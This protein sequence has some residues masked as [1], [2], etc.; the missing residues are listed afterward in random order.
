MSPI[1]LEFQ[2]F[3]NAILEN[4]RDTS[5]LLQQ[6]LNRSSVSV[7]IEIR[8]AEGRLFEN[9]E[10]VIENP[11]VGR[12][13]SHYSF[14]NVGA[15]LKAGIDI[16]NSRVA[17]GETKIQA[18]EFDGSMLSWS[19]HVYETVTAVIGRYSGL[20]VSLTNTSFNDA[21]K[22]PRF[23]KDCQGTTVKFLRP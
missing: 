7:P 19:H 6:A 5:A 10:A 1:S 11:H 8:V 9:F 20:N 13:S 2:Q 22:L 12:K 18:A 21:T 16:F 4:N 23:G 15:A 14:I 3:A 17:K